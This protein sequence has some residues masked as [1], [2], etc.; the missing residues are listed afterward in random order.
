MPYGRCVNHGNMM[1][2]PGQLD[3]ALHPHITASDDN[4]A[5]TGP[6]AVHDDIVALNQTGAG[7]GKLKGK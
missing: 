6:C 4:Y 2:I 3:G 5:M 1:S 7:L